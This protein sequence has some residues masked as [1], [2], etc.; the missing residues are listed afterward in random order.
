MIVVDTSV[1]VA[2]KGGEPEA[3][4]FGEALS[5]ADELTMSAG[6]YLEA[7][8]IAESR[9]GGRAALDTWLRERRIQVHPVDLSTAQLA[10]DAFARFGKGRH[11]AGLN[12]GDCFA[13]AL[14]KSLDAPLL[15][16]GKDFSQTDILVALVEP[17]A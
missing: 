13:Y 11:P 12:Y 2:I 3:V 17:S 1:F 15:H 8:M 5:R 7:A 4:V 6:N 16:K 10:A 14:A 9:F